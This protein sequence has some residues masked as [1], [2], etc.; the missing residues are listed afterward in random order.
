L[1]APLLCSVAEARENFTR[2]LAEAQ[3]RIVVITRHGR[4]V[5]WIRRPPSGLLAQ[6]VANT[7]VTEEL[8]KRKRRTM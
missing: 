8:G 1:K 3:D 2:V 6:R 4:A 5:A 7:V